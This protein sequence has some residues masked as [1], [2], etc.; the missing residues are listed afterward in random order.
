VTRV[1]LKRNDFVPNATRGGRGLGSQ[2]TTCVKSTPER[3]IHARLE[4]VVLQ[5]KHL[6]ASFRNFRSEP[7]T[8]AKTRTIFIYIVLRHI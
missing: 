1:A 3:L 5:T 7:I 6:L 4:V 8:A 2:I